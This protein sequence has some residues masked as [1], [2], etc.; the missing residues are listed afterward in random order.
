MIRLVSDI[1]A[2]FDKYYNIVKDVP[3][4]VQLGDFGFSYSVMEKL[5]QTKHRINLGNHENLDCAFQCKAVLGDFGY[6]NLNGIT[7]FFVRGSISIDKQARLIYQN[8]TGIKVWWEEEELPIDLMNEAL[9]W[10]EKIKPEMVITHD[11][12]SSVKPY[13]CNPDVMVSFGF[14]PDYTCM[15]QHL[16]QSMLDIHRPKL[17]IFGH[18][19]KHF[20]KKIKGTRFVCL[21]ELGYVDVKKIGKKF[22]LTFP[23]A[24][25]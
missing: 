19:H 18:F 13:I 25:V 24:D 12:S 22:I 23:K 5:D 20:D 17:W 6:T 7:F 1:H 10:Y 4:S 3:A 16:L 8:Q 21:P 14:D 15:T 2:Q 9:S 11:C